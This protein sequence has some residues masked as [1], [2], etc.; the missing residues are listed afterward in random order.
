MSLILHRPQKN[1]ES[2]CEPVLPSHRYLFI[3]GPIMGA[4]DFQS[5]ATDL[6]AAELPPRQVLHVAS[7]RWTDIAPGRRR[8][9][10][11]QRAWEKAHYRQAVKLGSAGVVM[12]YIAAETPDAPVPNEPGRAYGQGTR[13]EFSEVVGAKL[14]APHPVQLVVGIDPEHSG[15]GLGEYR[16]TAAELGIP[17]HEGLEATC[18]A[19]AALI[20]PQPAQ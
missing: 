13:S 16:H 18:V 15:R 9:P 7:P 5:E 11:A 3:A 1:H 10:G 19:A 6:L 12:F 14:F 20:L 2:S 4:R 8:E 17:I